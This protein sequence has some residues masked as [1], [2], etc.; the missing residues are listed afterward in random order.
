MA[1]LFTHAQAAN[2]LLLA[3]EFMQV[4]RTINLKRIKD[5]IRECCGGMTAHEYA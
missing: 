2:D 5:K 4:N 1:G 3:R